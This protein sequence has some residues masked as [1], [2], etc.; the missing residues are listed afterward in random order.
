MI[1][2]TKINAWKDQG[3]IPVSHTGERMVLISGSGK[4]L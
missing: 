2:F 1:A 3:I 4:E